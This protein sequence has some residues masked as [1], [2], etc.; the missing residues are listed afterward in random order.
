M[1]K[2]WKEFIEEPGL[3][4]TLLGDGVATLVAG[5]IGGPANTTYGAQ[6]Y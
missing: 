5:L 3:N 4:R 1:R 6:E 2:I